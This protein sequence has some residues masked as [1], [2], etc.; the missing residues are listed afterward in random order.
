MKRK[1]FF[2]YLLIMAIALPVCAAEFYRYVDRHGNVL[3]TDD[4]SNV[5]AEQRSDVT[6]YDQ[7]ESTA[8]I[9]E[10]S[11]QPKAQNE[12]SSAMEAQIRERSRLEVT[13]KE[14]DREYEGLIEE[15]NLLDEE[16]KQALTNAQIK[17]YNQKIVE[18]NG[19]IK[20][21]EERR[22]AYAA[23]VKAF[24]IQIKNNAPK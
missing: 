19:R 13:G 15:R 1:V 20:T 24:N 4:L 9:P 23:T 21:Y 2:G 7:S 22:D 10:E 8:P 6:V 11:K 14:L 3:Y 5:P 12:Q 17:S 18:F 16:K